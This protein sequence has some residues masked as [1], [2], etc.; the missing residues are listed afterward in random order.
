MANPLKK[1]SAANGMTSQRTRARMVN[2]L[3]DKGIHNERVLDAM[4]AVPR[5]LFVDEILIN[6][7]YDDVALPIGFGQTISQPYTVARMSELLINQTEFPQKILEIGTGCGYQTA[8]LLQM[9][10]DV[11]SIERLK[12]LHEK[13]KM[14]LRLCQL[15]QAKLIHGDGYLGLSQVAPF[16]GILVTAAAE[17]LPETL[18]TQLTAAGRLVLPMGNEEEQYLYLLEPLSKGVFRKTKLDSVF[19][20]PL[21][22]GKS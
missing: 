19:F 6:R 20:V 10:L 22:T 2:R 13:A 1:T 9:G 4:L 15:H 11:Y 8:I 12:A 3:Y 5:H 21:L 14:N 18:L 17:V 7:A 16:D